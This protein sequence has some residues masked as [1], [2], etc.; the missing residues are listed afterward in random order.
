MNVRTTIHSLSAALALFAGTMNVQA[1]VVPVTF[2]Y[3]ADNI[4]VSWWI[5]D[6]TLATA[7]QQALG[8]N[9]ANWPNPDTA[10]V[11]LNDAGSYDVIFRVQNLGGA[12]SD[13]PAALL[14]AITDG[15]LLNGE[16]TTSSDWDYAVPTGPDPGNA[17]AYAFFAGLSW[18][19]ATQWGS[20]GGSNIWT[21]NKPGP[22]SGIPASAQ[23]IWS[24]NNFAALDQSELYLRG[25]FNIAAVPVPGAVWL[26]GSAL[27]GAGLFRRRRAS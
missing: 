25:R 3:T 22:I 19:P 23:W 21:T 5:S 10:I 2:T 15:P 13:N 14:A 1:A 4:V 6:Q 8:P 18:A 17:G 27:L 26:L 20:N 9:A 7:T 11:N 16:L 24:G 12:A